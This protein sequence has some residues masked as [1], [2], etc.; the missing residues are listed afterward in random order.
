[1]FFPLCPKCIDGT[2]PISHT[3]VWI[4]QRNSGCTFFPPFFILY[5][6]HLM[7]PCLIS[8]PGSICPNVYRLHTFAEPHELCITR[9]ACEAAVII[10]GLL[11]H[12]PHL[13]ILCPH[14]SNCTKSHAYTSMYWIPH[15]VLRFC[16]PS[17]FTVTKN[18]HTHTHTH[19]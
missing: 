17:P 14:T 9:S 10:V 6:H 4:E 8:T 11:T 7:V 15:S 13:Y 2:Q 5:L 18:Q 12:T 3:K 1:M 19:T 16:L